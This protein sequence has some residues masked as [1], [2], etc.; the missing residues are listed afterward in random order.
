M[1]PLIT[2]VSVKQTV[3]SNGEFGEGE[4]GPYPPP[5]LSPFPFNHVLATISTDLVYPL[6]S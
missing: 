4:R 1:K 6:T 2:V 3:V 5:T